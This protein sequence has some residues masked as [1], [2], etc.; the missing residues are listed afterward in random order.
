MED[1]QPLIFLA[2]ALIELGRGEE[3]VAIIRKGF[4]VATPEQKIEI[5]ERLQEYYGQ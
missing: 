3:A 5:E 4:T 1:A 2:D